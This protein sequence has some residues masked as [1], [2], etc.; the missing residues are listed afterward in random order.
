MLPFKSRI[1]DLQNSFL[2]Y[3]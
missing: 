2:S 3:V 1:L